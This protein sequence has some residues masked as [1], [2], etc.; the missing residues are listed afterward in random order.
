MPTIFYSNQ[1]KR[2]FKRIQKQNKNLSILKSILRNSQS[3]RHSGKT[4]GMETIDSLYL[5]GYN[6]LV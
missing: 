2:D 3:E 1:V 5:A 6:K 4:G